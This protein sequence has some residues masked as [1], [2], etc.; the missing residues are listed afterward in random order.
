VKEIELF[1]K[2]NMNYLVELFASL[3][4]S[5]WKSQHGEQLENAHS[6]SCVHHWGLSN[7]KPSVTRRR[8]GICEKSS[9]GESDPRESGS[10]WPLNSEHWALSTKHRIPTRSPS[11]SW[12]WEWSVTGGP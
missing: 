11:T 12:G 7:W 6:R 1:E 2:S 10:A 5:H 9:K 4:G 3:F 8:S